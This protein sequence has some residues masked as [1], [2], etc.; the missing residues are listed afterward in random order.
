MKRTAILTCTSN[1]FGPSYF[2]T[3]L[4]ASQY[5]RPCTICTNPL[6]KQFEVLNRYAKPV[7]T[8]KGYKIKQTI[9]KIET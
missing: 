5:G 9:H 4:V 1:F 2:E 7:R 8:W 6:S 3:A